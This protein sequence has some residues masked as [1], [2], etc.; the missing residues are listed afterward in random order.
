MELIDKLIV[1]KCPSC[2]TTAEYALS[3]TFIGAAIT[4]TP[5]L[6]GTGLTTTAENTAPENMGVVQTAYPG[7]PVYAPRPL[8]SDQNEALEAETGAQNTA[9]SRPRKRGPRGSTLALEDQ[10]RAALAFN[11]EMTGQ[12]LVAKTGA[13]QSTVYMILRKI[14]SENTAPMESAFEVGEMVDVADL[15]NGLVAV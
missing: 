3:V 1:F 13:K 14:K 15:V 7:T 8:A 4:Q 6:N 9:Q 5:K 11:P 2:S 12:E 10:I